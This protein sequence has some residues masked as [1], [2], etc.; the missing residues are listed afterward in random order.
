MKKKKKEKTEKWNDVI[1][2]ER[3]RVVRAMKKEVAVA[4]AWLGWS[5]ELKRI[6]LLHHSFHFFANKLDNKMGA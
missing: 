6:L 2:M 3:K 4:L 5:A 1:M